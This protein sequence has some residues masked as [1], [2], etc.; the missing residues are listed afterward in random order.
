[1]NKGLF[2]ASFQS[3]DY[4]KSFLPKEILLDTNVLL[5]SMLFIRIGFLCW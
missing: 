5:M 3:I 4:F 2:L 1:M